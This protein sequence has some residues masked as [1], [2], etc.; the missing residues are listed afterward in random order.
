MLSWV[1]DGWEDTAA[2]WAEPEAV[3][4]ATAEYQADSDAVGRFIAER[5]R[6]RRRTVFATTSTLHT[7]WQNWAAKE[8]C[9]PMSRIAFGRVLD[10]KGYPADPKAHGRPR[11]RI[12]LWQERH[13]NSEESAGQ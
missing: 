5:V 8:G 10:A 11:R 2:R 3:L 13:A 12:R 1:I 7:R 9:L 6:Y 4:L